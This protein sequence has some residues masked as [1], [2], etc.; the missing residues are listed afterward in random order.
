MDI[1]KIAFNSTKD[2]FLTDTV[3]CL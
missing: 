3:L 2:T 1:A